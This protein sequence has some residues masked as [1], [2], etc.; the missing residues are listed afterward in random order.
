MLGHWGGHSFRSWAST[1]TIIRGFPRVSS[2]CLA[3][4]PSTEAF[5]SCPATTWA[6][7]PVRMT[8]KSLRRVY[9][10]R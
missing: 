7:Q 6:T 3:H 1:F 2:D 5:S 8:A 10:G 4:F 9:K